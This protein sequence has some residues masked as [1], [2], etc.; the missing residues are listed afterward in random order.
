MR[1]NASEFERWSGVVE[2]VRDWF[3]QII[4]NADFGN[5]KRNRKK[6]GMLLPVN[7]QF[8]FSKTEEAFWNYGKNVFPI[9]F[10]TFSGSKW[11]KQDG[12][13][14][15]NGSWRKKVRSSESEYIAKVV[16]SGSPLPE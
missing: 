6:S 1:H 10:V 5:Y 12:K 13:E 2:L 4:N 16:Y 9:F 3:S 15:N 7:L 8:P 14:R 11:R